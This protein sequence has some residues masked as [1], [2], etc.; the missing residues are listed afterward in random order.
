MA[1]HVSALKR[2]RGTERKTDVNRLRKS[3]MRT[4]IKK[5]R[6]LL[7]SKDQAGLLKELPVTYSIV[8][9]AARWGIIK[10]NTAARYKSRLTARVKA[11]VA[12]PAA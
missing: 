10:K 11:L 8:D 12:Q 3:R 2:V 5:F 4:Q 7:A 1:N 6:K 9:R